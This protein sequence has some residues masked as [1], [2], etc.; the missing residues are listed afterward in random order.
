MILTVA[1]LLEHKGIQWVIAAMPRIL[2]EFP[3][4]RYVVVGDGSYGSELER[5]VADALPSHLRQAVTFLGRVS[6][7]E[8]YAC[9]DMCDVFAMPSSEEGFGLVYVEASAFGKPVVGANVMGVPEAVVHGE[10]G[11]LVNPADVDALTNTILRLFR[12]AS[13]RERLGRNGR[14]YV[15]SELSWDVSAKKYLNLVG[16]LCGACQ[17][18]SQCRHHDV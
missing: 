4:A 12:D 14:R 15:E 9:Y 1:R 18:Q 10:T 11:F 3:D 2:A 7:S 17:A 5:A 16:Q 8:K 13:E 6:D